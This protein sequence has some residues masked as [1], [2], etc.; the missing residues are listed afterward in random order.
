[1]YNFVDFCGNEI[2]SY[3]AFDIARLDVPL[4]G[5]GDILKGKYSKSSTS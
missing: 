1:M 5:V 4:T 3:G 2:E